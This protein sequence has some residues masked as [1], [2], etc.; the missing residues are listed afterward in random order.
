MAPANL[1]LHDQ[2]MALRF[3][4]DEIAVF[5]GDAGNITAVGQSAGAFSLAAFLAAD[6][7]PRLFDKAVLMSAPVG[8]DLRQADEMAWMAATYCEAV[9]VSPQNGDGLRALDIADLMKGQLAILKAYM[10]RSAPDTILPPFMP[11]IDGVLVTA[12]LRTAVR[13]ST[14]V[15]AG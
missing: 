10:A 15:A 14:T 9:G 3:I 5:G 11:V 4:R 8:I 13:N 2:V 6:D 7:F 1:G 12:S